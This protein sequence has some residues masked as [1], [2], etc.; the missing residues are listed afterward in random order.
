MEIAVQVFKYPVNGLLAGKHHYQASTGTA[1]KKNMDGD[2]LFQVAMSKS[3]T[4]GNG[5]E[6][7]QYQQAARFVDLLR[8][9]ENKAWYANR[10]SAVKSTG[11]Q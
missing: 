10:R 3:A 7:V 11:S 5:E 4:S 6:R 9:Y 1:G 2:Q 8:P